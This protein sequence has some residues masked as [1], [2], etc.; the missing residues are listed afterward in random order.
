[1]E[2]ATL[3]DPALT[4]ALALAA[5]ML[6][7][8][9][10]GHLRLPGIILLLA[11]GRALGP[12]GLGI[13]EPESLGGGLEMLVGFAV[14]V[15]L[16]EGGMSLNLARLRRE[17]KSIRRLVTLGAVVTAVGGAIA[18][19]LIL[20]WE[21]PTA[22]LF[23]T[24]V[25]VT[26]PT[27]ITPLLRRIR[28]ERKVGTVLEAEG[29]FGDAI[30]ALIA[31]VTLEV[32]L[33]PSSGNLAHGP[34]DLV[35]RLGFGALMGVVLGFTV[36]F[37]MRFE[38]LV[39]E[40]YDN[41]MTLALVL[42]FFQGAN[43]LVPESGIVSVTVGGLVVGNSKTRL[44]D[45]LREFKE[46]LTV[47]MIGMLFVLLAADVRLEEVEA[48]GWPGLATVLAL[49]FVV[50]PLNVL[51]G[52]WGSDLNLRQKAFITWL[53]PRGIVAAAVASLFA[54]SLEEAGIA[55][56]ADLR[57]LVFLVIAV[58]VVVQGLSGGLIAGLLGLRR[59]SNSGFAIV[60]ANALGRTLGRALHETGNEVF[61]IDRSADASR[62]AESEGFRV[63]Y[64]DALS[65]SILYRAEL[66]TRAGLVSVT[67][68][69]PLNLLVA[70]KA[71]HRFKAPLVW[72]ALSRQ[73]AKA[74]IEDAHRIDSRVVFA[75]PRSLDTWI[76][77][78]ERSTA[79]RASWRFHGS[80]S[81]PVTLEPLERLTHIVLPLLIIQTSG[82]WRL[83]DEVTKVKDGDV[84]I[85]LAVDERREELDRGLAELGWNPVVAELSE[86]GAA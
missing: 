61:F 14:A 45:D 11:A 57:A 35:S 64:G 33:S 83:V 40:G 26:G 19:R 69:A 24:L 3:S 36:A 25:I 73:H 51:V 56:G 23:G 44:L 54:N 78:L 72:V 42:A 20:G 66:E 4:V 86:P 63:I 50:R 58:T 15:I 62:A 12:D 9:I 13:L 22:V 38:K 34:W 68:N 46:Q 79:S 32:V 76:L 59:A 60:G 6:A 16:F 82:A 37:L 1:M 84:L 17:A 74:G 49:M 52:T 85:G 71:R 30:G 80:G 27:V 21:W 70:D 39:P 75:A 8:A 43:S 48:L 28:V 77:R 55:G 31:V 81:T 47:L 5:G 7:Q 18:A 65:E 2:H 10:A 29:V 41:V 53:A 67:P